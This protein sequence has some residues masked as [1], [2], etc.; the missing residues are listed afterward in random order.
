MSRP[1]LQDTSSVA[2]VELSFKPS[3]SPGIEAPMVDV[4]IE[5][6]MTTPVSI[7]TRVAPVWRETF[8]IY[9]DNRL[10]ADRGAASTAV[11]SGLSIVDASNAA[12]E[13]AQ[14]PLQNRG[15]TTP[16]AHAT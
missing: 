11:R 5:H 15:E 10:G 12:R 16:N 13:T 2:G 6:L 14:K 7:R 4:T 1:V 8:P 3:P 9:I